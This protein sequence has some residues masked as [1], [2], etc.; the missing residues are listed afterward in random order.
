M[1]VEEFMNLSKEEKLEYYQNEVIP[2]IKWGF[3]NCDKLIPLNLQYLS[4]V[5][6]S[7]YDVKDFVSSV[8]YFHRI[9]PEPQHMPFMI[10]AT[11]VEVNAS[12]APVLSF[13]GA[14]SGYTGI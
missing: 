13:G 4:K 11:K 3:D 6:N 5:D 9:K 1:T 8:K 10:A 2:K 14:G 7:F 12:P